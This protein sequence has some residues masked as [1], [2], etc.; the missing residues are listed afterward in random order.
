M[1]LHAKTESK[2]QDN[3]LLNVPGRVTEFLLRLQEVEKNEEVIW[4]YAKHYQI[5]FSVLY[6]H[7]KPSL[8][9]VLSYAKFII[10]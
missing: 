5:F 3:C 2:I 10:K 6:E 9:H 1:L 8:I 4:F 7:K